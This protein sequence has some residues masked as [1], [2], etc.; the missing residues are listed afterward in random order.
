[1]AVVLEPS[2]IVKVDGEVIPGRWHED[3][4]GGVYFEDEGVLS[5]DTMS[6][7]ALRKKLGEMYSRQSR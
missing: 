5:T 4:L 1:M 3:E 2:G 7:D 6:K